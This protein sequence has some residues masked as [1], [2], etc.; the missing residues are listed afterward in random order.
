[1]DI[2][3]KQLSY[4][5]LLSFHA[6][7]RKYELYKLKSNTTD[8]EA[9]ISSDV[10]FATGHTIGHGLGLVFLGTAS[11]DQIIWEMFL[12]WEPDLLEGNLKQNKSF[13]LC[14]IAIQKLIAMRDSGFLKDWEVVTYESKPAIE[15]SFLIKFS[16]GFVYRGFV[17]CVLR[18]TKTGAVMV[19]ECKTSSAYEL[20]ASSY[21]NS[22]QAIGYSIVL[23]AIFPDLSSYKVQ[24]LIYRTK[25]MLYEPMEF[26][27]SFLDRALWLKEIMLDIETMRMYSQAGVYPMRGESCRAYG[28]DCEY[29]NLCTM[30]NTHLTKELNE[31]TENK[32]AKEN[33]TYQIQV[34]IQD[35]IAAQL[36]KDANLL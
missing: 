27:K 14:V 11:E 10:T 26:T 30:S 23:D 19:L 33:A 32:I 24:Y 7:P 2:R 17:D 15:L 1:M 12:R 28:R 5:S 31:E 9:D 22:A 18:N 36:D 16:D 34:G 4:S 6:C 3:L 25:Q 21:K 29:F 20:S 35:L 13:W 8:I